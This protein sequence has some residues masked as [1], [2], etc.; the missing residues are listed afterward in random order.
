M[1]ETQTIQAKRNGQGFPE[2]FKSLK[3]KAYQT[4]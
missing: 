2:T 1:K 3:T 4:E